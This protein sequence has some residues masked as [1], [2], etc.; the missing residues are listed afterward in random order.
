VRG[1]AYAAAPTFWGGDWSKV[2]TGRFDGGQVSKGDAEGAL[3]RLRRLFRLVDGAICEVN[4]DVVGFESYGFSANPDT[5]VVELVGA[6]KLRLLDYA[7]VVET[8][9][10]SSAR[11]LLLGKVPR[12][13]DEAKKAVKRALVAAGA[14]EGLSLDVTDAMCILNSMMAD[15]GGL[16]FANA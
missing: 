11:K 4:P 13:G 7:K 3:Y 1:F 9:N 10:Q 16:C 14:P 2:V 6:L 12:K 15:R 5:H 8:V